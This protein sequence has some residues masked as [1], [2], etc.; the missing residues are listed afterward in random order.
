MNWKDEFPQ[1]NRYFETEK[2]ILYCGDCRDILKSFPQESIDLVVTSP[3]YNVGI[4]YDSWNDKMKNEEYFD[5]IEN[6]LKELKSKLQIDARLAINVLLN[7]KTDGERI[8]PVAEYYLLLKKVGFGFHSIV[9][10]SEI[11]PHRIKY[12]AWGSWLSAS[13]PYI[14]DASECVLIGYNQ[15]WKKLDKGES[16]LTKEEFIELVAGQW[17]YFPQTKKL[18]EANFSLDLPLKAIKILSYKNDIVLDPFIGS[19][20]TAI[21]CERLNRRWIGIEISE[22]YCEIAKER[23]LKETN[24]N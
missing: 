9:I 5:F 18:T 24:A 12:T 6:V 3:P 19:G 16:T 8:S 23:I 11:K 21:A 14:Y 15:H 10:L 7:A 20:T 2:G 1:E 17:K 13:S 4:K 22:K